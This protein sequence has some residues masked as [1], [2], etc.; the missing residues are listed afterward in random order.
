MTKH[1]KTCNQDKPD[2]EFYSSSPTRCKE[3]FKAKVKDYQLRN[4]EVVRA[5]DKARS[6]RPERVAAREA[7]LKTEHGK[8][9]SAAARRAWA[10]R[11]PEKRTAH[12]ILNAA[13]RDGKII[14]P[15]RC[16]RCGGGGRIH[17]HHHDY[18]RPLA[19]DWLCSPCHRAEHKEEH[20]AREG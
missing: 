1:C 12:N 18:T 20:D 4:A 5:K 16:G 2:G 9:R 8:E 13:V 7:Y 15:K 17:A 10:K 6:N 11:N 14:K 3:C 19:V